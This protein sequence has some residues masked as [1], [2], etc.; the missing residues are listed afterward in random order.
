MYPKGREYPPDGHCDILKVL[1]VQI[2]SDVMVSAEVQLEWAV[3]MTLW[4]IRFDRLRVFL[5]FT[6]QE[7]VDFILISVYL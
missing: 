6:N 3:E 1:N 2:G 4:A 5:V 7:I